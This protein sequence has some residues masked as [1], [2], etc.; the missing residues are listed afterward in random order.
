MPKAGNYDFE[1]IAKMTTEQKR[2][3]VEHLAKVANERLRKL[4]KAGLKQYAYKHTQKM[5]M[6]FEKPRFST[7]L[8]TAESYMINKELLQLEDF[9]NRKTSTVK[10]AR[11]AH[12]K[13]IQTLK[14]SR[15][16][17]SGA[18]TR[19]LELTV[20]NSAD[21]FDFLSSLEYREMERL[22]ASEDLQ[23]FYLDVRGEI[24]DSTLFKLFDEFIAG[25]VGWNEMYSEIYRLQDLE[26][27]SRSGDLNEEEQREFE[28]FFR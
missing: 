5:L 11:E 24:P 25:K 20:E 1:A 3:V 2:Q 27:R 16:T 6:D 22:V 10:G 15:E 8:K 12:K 17:V 23:E 9:I 28:R 19:G 4:E 18:Y 7:N 14:K 26:Y 13:T 21:F